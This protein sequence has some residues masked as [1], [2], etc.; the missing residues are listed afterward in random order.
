MVSFNCDF[1]GTISVYVQTSH[2]WVMRMHYATA[3]LPTVRC[4]PT[5]PSSC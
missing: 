3:G 4:F 1:L 2:N 5:V